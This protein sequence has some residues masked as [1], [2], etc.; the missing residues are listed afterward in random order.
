MIIYFD[1]I[2]LTITNL[3]DKTIIDLNEY[4]DTEKYS[5]GIIYSN[6]NNLFA[7]IEQKS[8]DFSYILLKNIY[9]FD[10]NTNFNLINKINVNSV[11]TIYELKFSSCDSYII[12]INHKSN[13]V[14][15][16]SVYGTTY[17]KENSNIKISCIN[18]IDIYNNILIAKCLD[19][20]KLTSFSSSSFK[21]EEEKE[22]DNTKLN[23]FLGNKNI[24]YIKIISPDKVILLFTEKDE[25]KLIIFNL[26][27]CE[28]L[29]QID[30]PTIP[31]KKE[32]TD[33]F[34]IDFVY[35]KYLYSINYLYTYSHGA[36]SH[37]LYSCAIIYNIE[38]MNKYTINDCREI[39]DIS[40][41]DKIIYRN[42]KYEELIGIL[43]EDKYEKIN[44]DE[45]GKHNYKIVYENF[46]LW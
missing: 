44:N 1:N 25:L 43:G 7:I 10:I 39:C 13:T 45:E 22:E 16:Y 31:L 17:V 18:K 36:F 20:Y 23:Y 33:Q 27:T 11:E 14:N 4:F 28:F 24:K 30:I 5:Y 40:P 26:I 29:L 3:L 46:V 34:H 32:L 2:N 38:T 19:D 42:T 41:D 8:C 9:V 6:T 35:N 21:E 15:I 37:E 12:G